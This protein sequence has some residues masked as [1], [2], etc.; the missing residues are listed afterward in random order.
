[1]PI[2]RTHPPVAFDSAWC[3]WSLKIAWQNLSILVIIVSLSAH[4]FRHIPQNWPVF[5]LAF[6]LPDVLRGSCF[7]YRNSPKQRLAEASPVYP[8]F[9][10]VVKIAVGCIPLWK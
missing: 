4:L 7:M 1:M 6:G 9:V 5:C 10:S 3:L 8:I 2:A